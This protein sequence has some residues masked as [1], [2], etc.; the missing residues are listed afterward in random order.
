MKRLNLDFVENQKKKT[1][2]TSTSS[3]HWLK[4]KHP[5]LL[6]RLLCVWEIDMRFLIVWLNHFIHKL[7]FFRFCSD[8][9]TVSTLTRIIRLDTKHTATWYILIFQDGTQMWIR[10]KQVY[11][12][13]R[14]VQSELRSMWALRN[15]MFMPKRIVYEA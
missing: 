15:G 10:E 3:C 1:K 4:L 6:C 8:I 2:N 11:F 7:I 14:L 12:P 13:I 5:S 9:R